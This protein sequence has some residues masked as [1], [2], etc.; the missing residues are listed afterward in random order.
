MVTLASSRLLSQLGLSVRQQC[1]TDLAPDTCF[2][3]AVALKEI[4]LPS[5]QSGGKERYYKGTVDAWRKIAADEGSR[6]FFKGAL[7]NVLRGAGQPQPCAAALLLLFAPRIHTRG[8][9]CYRARQISTTSPVCFWC[10][11]LQLQI[12]MSQ[13][14]SL[15]EQLYV[16]VQVEPWCSCC[17]MRLRR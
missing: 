11:V 4:T 17:T 5:L 16:S 12:A 1:G 8:L 15:S 13:Q 2:R 14:H 3:P 9:C 7:S 10:A 6:A